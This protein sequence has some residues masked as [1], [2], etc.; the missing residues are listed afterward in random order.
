VSDLKST[1]KDLQPTRRTRLKGGPKSRFS[2]SEWEDILDTYERG[3]TSLV[4][5]GA[6]DKR[7][8]LKNFASQVSRRMQLRRTARGD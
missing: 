4:I 6:T 8:G 1:L 2:E 7:L 5:W 3:V